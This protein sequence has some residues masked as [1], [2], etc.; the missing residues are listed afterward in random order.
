MKKIQYFFSLSLVL[1]MLSCE[2]QFTTIRDIELPLHESKLAVFASIS[3]D[4]GVISLSNS[5]SIDD[6]RPYHLLFADITILENGDEFYKFHY[7]GLQNTGVSEFTLPAPMKTGSEYTLIAENDK[8]GKATSVQ[9]LPAPPVISNIEFTKDGI[10]DP[11]GYKM[12]KL[13]LDID[14]KAGEENFYLIEVEGIQIYERDTFKYTLNLESFDPGVRSF[15]FI[16]RQGVII[17]DKNFDGTLARIILRLNTWYEVSDLNVRIYSITKDHYHF[18][19]S[20][21]QYQ[22]SSGNPFAEPVN[23]HNNIENGYG[24]F[25]VNSYVEYLIGQ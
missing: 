21:D 12:D 3:G 18:L 23:V 10:I 6:N 19:L 2:D 14:D 1:M 8:F 17:S 7:D 25:Q 24:L 9:I 16:D 5:K 20:Y 15:W 11:D 4:K 22:N 13:S